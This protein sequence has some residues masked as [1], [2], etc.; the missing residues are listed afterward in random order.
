[1]Y[2][3]LDGTDCPISEP[4]VFDPKWYSHKLNGPGVRYEIGISIGSGDIVWASGGL[5]CGDWPDLKIA[6]D[7]YIF[8]T[9][10]E[11]TLADKGYNSKQYFRQPRNRIEKALL[12]RHET[13]NGRLKQFQILN[14]RFR[15]E[16]K[17]HP[18][19]FHACVNILQI[20]IQ[21]GAALF[22]VS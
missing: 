17:K 3:T 9:E 8:Y 4:T 20:C 7:L 11:V 14:V 19:V 22:E 16:L 13:L 5:P 1:M 2:V 10:N 6:K 18:M 21:N 15:N 12:A